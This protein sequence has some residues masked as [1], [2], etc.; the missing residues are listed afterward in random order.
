MA[1]VLVVALLALFALV[2]AQEAPP[3]SFTLVNGILMASSTDTCGNPPEVY[4]DPVANEN[5]TCNA[6]DDM[7][8]HPPS[9]ALNSDSTLWW[10]SKG[11]V[12]NASLDID[13]KQ[14]MAFFSHFHFRVSLL[15][16]SGLRSPKR[17]TS[18]GKFILAPRFCFG[19]KDRGRIVRSARVCRRQPVHSLPER[20]W[21]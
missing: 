5:R 20:L 8:D 4:F 10:Q 9:D 15:P 19:E 13:L 7:N 11:G 18:D 21:R 3:A 17:S 12:E 1:R 16:V 6:T 14:V 2:G